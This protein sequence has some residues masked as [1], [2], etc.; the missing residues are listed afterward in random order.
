MAI[1][2]PG[3]LDDSTNLPSPATG[4]VIP[5]LAD[6]N[7]SLAAIALETKIGIDASTPT[8]NKVLRGTGTGTSSWAQAVLTTDVTGVLPVANGGTAGSTASA[9]RTALG[10]VIGTD[11]VAPNQDTTGKSAK[12]DALNSATTVVNVSS[13]T[14]PTSGQI[15]TATSGTAATWQT[16]ASGGDALVANPLSQFAS[17]TSAQLA[18]VISNETGSG[19]LAFGTAPTLSLPVIDNVKLGY[20]TTATAAG[21]TTLTNASNLQQFFTGTT[22]Q[23]VVLPVTSTLALGEQYIITNNSTGVVTVQSSGANNILAMVASSVATFTV[24][25]TS[26]TDATSWSAE[27]TGFPAVTGTGSNVLATSPTLV[28]PALG[29][30]ASGVATNMTGL[31]LS[32]G[33]TGT[34]PIANGG[35]ANTTAT[36]AFDALSPM[37]TAGDIIY[38][39]ASGTRTR[40]GIGTALQQLRTN[41]GATAPEWFTVA[42]AGNV[43]VDLV[44]A[45]SGG[46]H[47]T[48]GAALAAASSGQTIWV[49]SGTYTETAQT[50]ATTNLT[51][52]GEGPE[53][54]VIDLGTNVWTLSGAGLTMR[55]V[56]FTNGTGGK[57]DI[58]GAR[59]NVTG[60]KFVQTGTSATAAWRFTAQDARVIGNYYY[61]NQTTNLDGRLYFN[62]LYGTFANNLCTANDTATSISGATFIFNQAFET[63]T[64]NVF[65]C[66]TSNTELGIFVEIQSTAT[67]CTFSGNLL[68][69]LQ[70][71]NSN[72][73]GLQCAGAFTSITGN[74]IWGLR[75]GVSITSAAG[76][77]SITG[78]T[79][80]SA[81]NNSGNIGVYVQATEC[82]VTG[83]TLIGQNQNGTGVSVAANID[84][85]VI[86]GNYITGHGKGV[87]I[88]GTGNDNNSIVGNTFYNHTT[89]IDDLGIAT[90]ISGNGDANVNTEKQFFLMK[91]TSG[92]A[93]A[94]GDVVILKSVAAGNEVTTTTTASDNQVFGIAAQTISDAASGYIQTL[95]KTISLKV[96]GTTDIA[97][98]DFLTT[99]TTAKIARK[100]A[101]GTLGTTPGDLAFAIAL[102]AY[103]A[104]NS[105]GVI[106]AIL[107]KPRRL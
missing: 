51:V 90:V 102:E 39:G 85:V 63:I 93:L 27:Y 18:G 64:G 66:L 49:K 57:L 70:G 67:N 95:G 9:A 23:T 80:K 31:P 82:V 24:I 30:P 37:T 92:G 41:A 40:L 91:N 14:A 10:L 13:A 4:A 101:A 52:L 47:T 107:I 81:A 69:N 1:N 105:S 12:T 19:L 45:A 65:K 16:P 48:L 7:R 103:T 86:S 88:T 59:A 26:G 21:T 77:N 20:T 104:D 72:G 100:A 99:F 15:L 54:V 35:T 29:T 74:T 98:G 106:D 79:H 36:A 87:L 94:V 34:L 11:V 56:G 89:A 32:T 68:V 5:A 6:T 22:T 62:S 61:C 96:D 28:T 44:V 97:I 73:Y 3:S 78:N 58:T 2:Y 83:N 38:G 60:C 33:V 71:A 42:T 53:T 17:T 43:S 76:Q 75:V 46:D 50:V 84:H 55:D 8:N 25:L